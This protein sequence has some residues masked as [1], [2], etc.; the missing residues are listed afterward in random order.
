MDLR[1]ELAMLHYPVLLF[2]GLD[3]PFGEQ[4]P[5]SIQDTFVQ[6]SVDFVPIEN[7]GH[8]WHECPDAFYPR[9]ADFLKEQS[10]R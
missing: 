9:V 8:F 7:C 5:A 2:H 6:S 10:Q 1:D 3:D 4:M